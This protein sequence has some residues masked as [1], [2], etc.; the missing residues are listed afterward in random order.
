MG[1]LLQTM[2]FSAALGLGGCAQWTPSPPPDFLRITEERS[3]VLVGEWSGPYFMMDQPALGFSGTGT[4]NIVR[5][6]GRVVHFY[7]TWE[8]G[9]GGKARY[10]EQG[11][12][13]GYV[14]GDGYLIFDRGRNRLELYRT[15]NPDIFAF[16]G[17][18]EI[19]SGPSYQVYRRKGVKLL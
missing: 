14:S 2:V 6:E 16:R 17:E 8:W 3:S 18:V 13:E 15:D 19:G 9:D 11:T 7:R 1:K 10:P 12:Q 4:L 5:T